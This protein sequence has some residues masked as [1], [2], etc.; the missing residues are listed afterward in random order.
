MFARCLE[1]WNGLNGAIDRYAVAIPETA[2]FSRRFRS[3]GDAIRKGGAVPGLDRFDEHYRA[4]LD[5]RALESLDVRVSLG[6]RHTKRVR[7]LPDDGSPAFGSVSDFGHGVMSEKKRRLIERHFPEDLHVPKLVGAGES[8]EPEPEPEPEEPDTDDVDDGNKIPGSHKIEVYDAGDKS[9]EEIVSLACEVFD[10]N[11]WNLDLL[12]LDLCSDIPGVPVP[13][14][15]NNMRVAY[16]RFHAQIAK[17]I[18]DADFWMTMGTARPETAYSGKRPNCYRVYDKPAELRYQ[19]AKWLKKIRSMNKGLSRLAPVECNCGA[20]FDVTSEYGARVRSWHLAIGHGSLCEGGRS[21]TPFERSEWV[22]IFTFDLPE[23]SDFYPDPLPDVLTRVEREMGGG[24][25]PL[26]VSKAERLW[27]LAEFNPF[28]RLQTS[29]SVVLP[30]GPESGRRVSMRDHLAGLG[31]R[32]LIA[33]DPGG[34][35][36]ALNYVRKHSNNHGGDILAD[37]NAYIVADSPGV[38]VDEIFERY[39]DAVKAQI[40]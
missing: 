27:S 37:L 4:V 8:P 20:E 34:L 2:N 19:F 18:P 10:V 26:E 3:Y 1:R 9:L 17:G 40:N 35:Q 11:P 22:R 31:L 39:R 32:Y 21:L 38:T 13:W 28:D 25:I 36:G 23:F 33:N 14:F 6:N 30:G 24:R 7:L 16:K 29:N 12:R 5:L 15:V